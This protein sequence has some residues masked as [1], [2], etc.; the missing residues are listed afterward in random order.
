MKEA[1][2]NLQTAVATLGHLGT[3]FVECNAVSYDH[4]TDRRV[5]TN[6]RV[7]LVYSNKLNTECEQAVR[8]TF[9]DA[10]AEVERLVMERE[11]KLRTVEAIIPE[12]DDGGKR[13]EAAEL[14][15]FTIRTSE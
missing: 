15:G 9:A 8:P 4:F 13:L 7:S 2:D 10:L 6:W 3:L 12:D 5:E 1:L 11:Q 14:E